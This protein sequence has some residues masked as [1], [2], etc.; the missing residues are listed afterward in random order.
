MSTFQALLV[1]VIAVLPGAVYTIARESHGASWAWRKTDAA[2]LI[3]RFLATSAAFHA[4]L[5]PA[6]YYGYRHVVVTGATAPKGL[7]W[8]WWVAIAAYVTVPYL[9]GVCMEDSREWKPS[10]RRVLGWP[11]NTLK[12]LLAF[13]SGIDPEPR[14]WDRLFSKNRTGYVTLKLKDSQE[15]KAGIWYRPAYASAYGEDQELYIAEQIAVSPEGVVSSDDHGNPVYLGVGLLIRWS[16][17]E[18]VEFVDLSGV[19]G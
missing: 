12:R 13:I 1:A 8:S 5:A 16:E 7:P 3:F 17:I 15:W 9:V 10:S 2:T 18:Y 4:L 19:G 14:A 11:K 6:T